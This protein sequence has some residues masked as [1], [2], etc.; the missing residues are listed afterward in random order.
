MIKDDKIPYKLC[1][2]KSQAEKVSEKE[3]ISYYRKS[4]QGIGNISLNTTK[5]NNDSLLEYSFQ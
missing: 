1:M 5:N 4:G 2:E 3:V